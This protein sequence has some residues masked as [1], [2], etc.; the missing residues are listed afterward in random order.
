MSTTE[1][2]S[3]HALDLDYLSK[4]RNLWVIQMG[5]LDLKTAKILTYT[6]STMQILLLLR[7]AAILFALGK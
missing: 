2:M 4:T 3:S 7:V 6:F 1:K 5:N